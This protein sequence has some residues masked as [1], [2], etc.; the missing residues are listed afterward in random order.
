MQVCI[1]ACDLVYLLTLQI[2][3]LIMDQSRIIV[4]FITK[5]TTMSRTLGHE[6]SVISAL[7]Y[8]YI[9]SC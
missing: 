7:T 2:F 4:D 1:I 8:N 6:N 3:T 5:Y 9:Y